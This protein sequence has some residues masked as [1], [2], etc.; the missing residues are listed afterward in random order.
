MTEKEATFTPEEI[1][2]LISIVNCNSIVLKRSGD[3]PE[4]TKDDIIFKKLLTKDFYHRK[5][6]RS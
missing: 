5:L 3:Y 2:R 1:Q 6:T 4:Q